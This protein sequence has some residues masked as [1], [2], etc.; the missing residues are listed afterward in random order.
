MA[1]RYDVGDGLSIATWLLTS[2]PQKHHPAL[3]HVRYRA[4]VESQGGVLMSRLLL[5]V[6]KHAKKI[7]VVR[8]CDG[9]NANGLSSCTFE[10]GY[11][12]VPLPPE[13]EW[14]KNAWK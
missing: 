10:C 12:E 13:T 6:I 1:I 2:L 5:I 8:V 7:F 14:M 11:N 4:R 9:D 3:I